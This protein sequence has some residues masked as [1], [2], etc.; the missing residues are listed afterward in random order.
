M[1]E[2]ITCNVCPRNCRLK[3]NQIGFCRVRK[4]I[5][6]KI[7]LTDYGDLTSLQVDPIEK[8][9]L[10]H[11]LPA[12]KVL[13]VGMR[14]CNLACRFCQNHS[15]AHPTKSEQT[16]IEN[17]YQKKMQPENIVSIAK[18][19]NIPMIAFTYNEPIIAMEYVIDTFS[20][21]KNSGIKNIIV[22]NGYLSA[23][24]YEAF[25]ENIDAANIDLKFFHNDLYRQYSSG[26]LDA[27]LDTLLYIH[28]KNIHLEITTLILPGIN[29]SDNLIAEQSKWMVKNLG[30]NTPL[31][32]SAFHPDY[33]MT[34]HPPTPADTL[35]A[36]QKTARKSGL[37]NVYTGNIASDNHSVCPECGKELILR[38]GY[39]TTINK[40]FYAKKACPACGA[41]ISEIQL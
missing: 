21:A 10:Y 7:I 25:F 32:L 22:S 8:K 31:H 35:F 20:I 28:S 18:G 9:P 24:Y 37:K 15:I 6:G 39:R 33:K 34:S 30:D 36:L 1:A 27:V 23:D 5:G 11:F 12:Q 13:S 41:R 2:K 4:N 14:G 26:T 19:E 16:A 29:D 38:D 40:D 3:E 17:F